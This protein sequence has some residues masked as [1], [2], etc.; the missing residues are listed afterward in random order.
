MVW[1]W[2]PFTLEDLREAAD[3]NEYIVFDIRDETPRDR[4]FDIVQGDLLPELKVRILDGGVAFDV[5]GATIAFN[6]ARADDSTSLKVTAGVGAIVTASEGKIKY[7]F[8]GTQTDTADLYVGE[9]KLTISASALS[10]PNQKS[11]KFFIRVNK[12]VA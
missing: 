2:A 10:V 9:F 7:V 5:T 1:G 4:F 6:M 3:M 12:K 8:T 11:H